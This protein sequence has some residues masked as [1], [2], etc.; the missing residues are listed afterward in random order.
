[1]PRVRRNEWNFAHNVARIITEILGEDS[2]SDSPLGHAEPELTEFRGARRLDLIIFRRENPLEPIITGETKVPWAV[3]GR[4]PY[5]SALVEAAHGKASRVGALYFITW[6]VR[7]V[8]VWKTDDPGIALLHRVVFDQELILEKLAEPS[9]LDIPSVQEALKNGVR[10]LVSFLHSLVTGPPAPTFLPLDRL[11]I[12]TIEAA[13]DFPIEITAAAI[14]ERVEASI[15]TRRSVEKWMRDVQGWIV[16]GATERDNIERASRFTC[17]VL[18][19]RLCF[20]NALR[21]KY[22]QL[23]RLTVSNSINTGERLQQRLNRSFREAERFTGNYETVFRGDFGDNLPFFADEA[24]PAWRELIRSLDRYDFAHINLDVIGAM[25]EQLIKPSERHRF[26]QHYTKP[27]VVD[28]INS[29]VIHTGHENVLDPACGGGTFLVRAYARKSYLDSTEDHTQLLESIYGC[30]VLNYACHLSVINLAI[31]DLIDDDN[32][33]RIHQGDFLKFVPGRTFSTQPVRIQA[34]GLVSETRSIVVNQGQFDAIV[35]NPPYIQSRQISADDRQFYYQLAVD[36]WPEYPWRRAS[37]IYPYFWTHSAK[38]LRDNGYLALLTQAAWLDVD[39]GIPVQSWMLNNFRIIAILETEAEPWF[40]GARVATAV[41]IL[42]RESDENTR[43]RN[44]VRFVQFR[45][46]LSE[47][48]GEHNSEA[49]RQRAAK[50]LCDNLLNETHDSENENHRIRIVS[51]RELDGLGSEDGQYVG[52][53]WGRF[54]RSTNTLYEIQRHHADRFVPLSR[55]ASIQRGTTTNCDAFFIVTNVSTVA[56]NEL[57]NA[58]Q[59]REKYGV[60]RNQV[61]DGRTLIVQRRDGVDFALEARHLVPILRTARDY[62]WFNTEH[63]GS[64]HFAVFITE[65]RA[66]LSRL[67]EAYVRAGERERWHLSASFHSIEGNWY[68]LRNAGENAPI[69]FIKTMQYSPLVLL[70]DAGLLANQRLYNVRPVEGVSELALCAVLNSTV[71]ACERYAA[72]KALG[73]EAAIDVEVFSARAFLTPD[74]T[75]F[76]SSLVEQLESTMLRLIQRQVG[77][78]LEDA[79][80]HAGHSEAK[81]HIAHYPVNAEMWP[82]EFHDDVRQ[83]LDKLVLAGLGVSEGE[84]SEK[85]ERIYNELTEHVRKLRLLELE[86]QINR[87]GVS[88]G[89]DPTPR[90]LADEIWAHLIED[91]SLEPRMI[92]DNFLDESAEMLTIYLP[93]GRLTVNVPSLFDEGRFSCV[94][95]STRL[96]FETEEQLEFVVFLAEQGIT[97]SIEVPFSSEICNQVTTAMRTYLAELSARFLI[98]AEEVTGEGELQRRIVRE[99]IK[100]VTRT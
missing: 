54:L 81:A 39:Y 15:R 67:A 44:A 49:E 4:T 71:F 5:N 6:N 59:F 57:R 75:R 100:R 50:D 66:H 97:G 2:Y 26:G 76:P 98:A 18:V 84:I 36:E 45:K 58:Q 64:D 99:G 91:E 41:T 88:T 90:Q 74:L 77:P 87:R 93:S 95:G 14:R 11:F 83:E 62:S 85:Q 86:A 72:V 9:D 35:G 70:N 61:V 29:F 73:R 3:D 10:E 56:L 34:G 55:L 37:D 65:E 25:Y 16:S 69:L 12:A 22:Q 94:I 46:R 43:S 31:R 33:P 19:N 28:L 7:R 53:K 79:L 52:S 23:P 82:L 47:I 40:T 96:E 24:T 21:R 63:V 17:Y 60:S 13:L 38:L 20:Y 32:F 51:Q 78:M 42:R 1:M 68:T 80:L 89:T 48:I 92:P 27:S 8:V 30:D